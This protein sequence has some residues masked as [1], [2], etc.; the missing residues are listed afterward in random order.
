MKFKRLNTICNLKINYI[1]SECTLWSFKLLCLSL[2]SKKIIFY[3]LHKFYVSQFKNFYVSIRNYCIE[4]GRSKN[5]NLK[6]MVSRIKL[7][8]LM[9]SR[10][11]IGLKKASW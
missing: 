9:V 5:L 1:T 6:W 3:Y 8:E 2:W 7:R 11:F 4:S 10:F